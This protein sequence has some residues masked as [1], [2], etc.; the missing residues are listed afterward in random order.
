MILAGRMHIPTLPGGI[1]IGNRPNLG[2]ISNDLPLLRRLFAKYLIS[3]VLEWC[4]PAHPPANIIPFGL[5]PKHDLVEPWRAILDGRSTNLALTPMKISMH[6]IRACSSLFGPGSYVFIKDISAAYHNCLLGSTCVRS[7][8]GCSSCR[9]PVGVA[10]HPCIPPRAAG[11]EQCRFRHTG[12][13]CLLGDMRLKAG[14]PSEQ[15][16]AYEPRFFNGCR[17]AH[18]CKFQL[19]KAFLRCAFGWSICPFCLCSLRYQD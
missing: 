16:A 7:C 14:T 10:T 17:P 15:A 19:S 8:L 2:S 9:A 11:P 5:V 3:G 1:P 13:Q 12:M 6:G 4:P 18:G